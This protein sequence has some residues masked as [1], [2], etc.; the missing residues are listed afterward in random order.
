MP[1]LA[2]NVQRYS[3]DEAAVLQMRRQIGSVCMQHITVGTMPSIDA[4]QK[5]IQHSASY[6]TVRELC[7]FEEARARCLGFDISFLYGHTGR[8]ATM[9]TL[10][11]R[12]CGCL[13]ADGQCLPPDM[14]MPCGI[15]SA[16]HSSVSGP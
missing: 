16:T 2:V 7:N 4:A 13:L 14:M 3:F 10:V 1:N 12:L 6:G 8:P 11:R 9:G 15:F 5:D